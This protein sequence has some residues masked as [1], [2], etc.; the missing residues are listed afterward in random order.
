MFRRT[1]E[2]KTKNKEDFIDSVEK[3]SKGGPKDKLFVITLISI[4]VSLSVFLFV[5]SWISLGFIIGYWIF[6]QE[7]R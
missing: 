4:L 6:G 5:M 3:V 7:V 2:E 1:E